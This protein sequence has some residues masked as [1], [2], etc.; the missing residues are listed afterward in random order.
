MFERVLQ[1]LQDAILAGE[2][3]VT[4]PH[5]LEELAAEDLTLPDAETAILTGR[6]TRRYTDDPRG[7]RY[8]VVGR[9]TDGR[10]L[11]VIVRIKESGVPLWITVYLEVEETE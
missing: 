8:K 11:A 3:E 1:K 4:D 2:Y 10:L 9:S 6:I 5:F 7:T